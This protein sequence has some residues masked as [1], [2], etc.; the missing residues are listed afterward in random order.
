MKTPHWNIYQGYIQ[1]IPHDREGDQ[2]SSCGEKSWIVSDVWDTRFY[3]PT[4]KGGGG[5]KNTPLTMKLTSNVCK[6][7]AV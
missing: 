3:A 5:N 6:L 4:K 7:K 1:P 2:F